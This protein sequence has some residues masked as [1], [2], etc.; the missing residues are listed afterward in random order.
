MR[1]VLFYPAFLI[2][3]IA[4]CSRPAAVQ[5]L[6]QEEIIAIAESVAEVKAFRELDDRVTPCI[7]RIVKPSCESDYVTCRDNAWVVQYQMS[8]D[9]P[10]LSDG[11]LSVNLLIDGG[12]GEIVSRFP[13]IEYFQDRMFC[14]EDYDCLCSLPQ[15]GSAHCL[16]FI[17]EP[18]ARD[19]VGSL[20]EEEPLCSECLCRDQVCRPISPIS[21]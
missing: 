7:E 1:P 17:Y 20:P 13:E 14:R 3:V 16:N 5:L 18:L 4:G 15:H 11:R 19:P 10:I 6:S 2:V 12:T 9:C 8:S 21:E